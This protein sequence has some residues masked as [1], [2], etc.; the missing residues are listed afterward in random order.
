MFLFLLYPFFSGYRL[1]EHSMQDI[2]KKQILLD[3]TYN[4]LTTQ[5]YVLQTVLRLHLVRV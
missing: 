3:V 4:F 1:N 5:T 2:M